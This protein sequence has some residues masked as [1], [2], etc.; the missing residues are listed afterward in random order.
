[1]S[2]TIKLQFFRQAQIAK[3]GVSQGTALTGLRE[4][5]GYA[6]KYLTAE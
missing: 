4:L 5:G 3:V 6:P 1:M 2:L